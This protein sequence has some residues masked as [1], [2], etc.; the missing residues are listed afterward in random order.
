M[1]H[2]LCSFEV[3]LDNGEEDGTIT[4]YGSVFGNIDSYGDTVAP[5]AFRKTILDSKTGAKSWP[6][7]LLQHGDNTADGQMPVGIWTRMEEDDN[8]LRLEGK[9]ANTKRG[10][11]ALALLKMK[12][13]P[14]LD[15]LSIGYRA[16]D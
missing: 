6:A 1:E 16:K 8:G 14:A 13:R 11:D 3:K 15:G 10:R 2:I 12:P 4:G 7:M 5:G 9:L